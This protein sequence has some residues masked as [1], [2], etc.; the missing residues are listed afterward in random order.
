MGRTHMDNQRAHR[1][2]TRRFQAALRE[3][4]ICRVRKGGEGGY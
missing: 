2:A 4:R 3:D 1:T